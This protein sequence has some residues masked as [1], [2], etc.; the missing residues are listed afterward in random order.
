MASSSLLHLSPLYLV[1]LPVALN[2]RAFPSAFLVPLAVSLSSCTVALF[3]KFFF[4]LF[5]S[6]HFC[7]LFCRSVYLCLPV[8][9]PLDNGVDIQAGRRG[10]K[11]KPGQGVSGWSSRQ[12]MESFQPA[13]SSSFNWLCASR[14][15]DQ[16]LLRQ[17]SRWYK[18]WGAVDTKKDTVP[19]ANGLWNQNA[20]PTRSVWPPHSGDPQ[21]AQSNIEGKQ[22]EICP[23][24]ES[25]DKTRRICQ[26]QTA[27]AKTLP[28]SAPFNPPNVPTKWGSKDPKESA[29]LGMTHS[30][31]TNWL[32]PW[33]SH[34]PFLGRRVLIYKGRNTNSIN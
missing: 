12:P 31:A 3:H 11:L 24:S 1:F 27:Q 33:L 9:F 23:R 21:L 10:K 29:D 26:T 19:R 2:C 15:P 17:P 4:F 7:F 14:F 20:W 32:W 16:S 22:E 5:L 28:S 18:T 25:T 34:V 6:L 13:K 30:F 8:S